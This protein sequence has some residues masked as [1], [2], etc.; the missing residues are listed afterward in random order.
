MGLQ[1]YAQ[2]INDQM[3]KL[4]ID[5]NQREK[6]KK[7]KETQK[8]NFEKQIRDLQLGLQQ[9]KEGTEK[10]DNFIKDRKNRLEGCSRSYNQVIHNT[11]QIMTAVRSQD[12][13]DA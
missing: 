5:I 9:V 7:E 1:C 10:D 11:Q 3:H 8:L 13:F 6:T 12:E 4:K 2:E